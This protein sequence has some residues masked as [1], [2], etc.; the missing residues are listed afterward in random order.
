M[1]SLN[2]L[3]KIH[4]KNEQVVVI[5]LQDNVTQL[6]LLEEG[7]N[8]LIKYAR[9]NYHELCG[10]VGAIEYEVQLFDEKFN[11]LVYITKVSKKSDQA[12]GLSKD[13]SRILEFLEQETKTNIEF[14]NY[15]S[16]KEYNEYYLEK[17]AVKIF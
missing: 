17:L 14:A 6:N 9:V 10:Y 16:M 12:H 13:V 1:K 4:S 2:Q 8:P 5:A 15:N 3:F 11:Q 7:F